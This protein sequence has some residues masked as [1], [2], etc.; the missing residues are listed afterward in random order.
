MKKLTVN[1]PNREYDILIGNDLLKSA[2]EKITAI[3]PKAKK[4][5]IVTDENVAPLYLSKIK[6]SLQNAGLSV[7]EIILAEGE[8]TKS[9]D[10]LD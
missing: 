8:E 10:N 9:L 6:D 1:I 3:S 4:A 5:V 2:G 7:K